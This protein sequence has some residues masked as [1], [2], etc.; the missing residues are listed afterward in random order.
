M[1]IIMGKRGRDS[2][3]IFACYYAQYMDIGSLIGTATSYITLY[4]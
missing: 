2:L 1:K 3:T 4:S